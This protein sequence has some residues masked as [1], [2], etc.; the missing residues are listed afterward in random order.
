MEAV[1]ERLQVVGVA[2]DD[3]QGEAVQ[4]GTAQ[5]GTVVRMFN[6][7]GVVRFGAVRK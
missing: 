2:L 5:V 3:A 1:G 7:G 4:V 6:A